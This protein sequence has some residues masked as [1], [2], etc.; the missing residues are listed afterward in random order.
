M[1]STSREATIINAGQGRRLDVLGHVVKVM[2]SSAD[3]Q[4]QSFV[5]E[6]ISPPG[7]FVPPHAHE[8]ED[9]YGYIVEG[10]FEVFVDGQIH[11]ATT[12]A[13]LY[14]PRHTAHG[15]RNSGSTPCKMIW[16]STPGANVDPFF[17]EL[18]ALPADAPPDMEKVMGIFARHDMQVFP[19]PWQ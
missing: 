5:F 16:I 7:F 13:V 17:E 14:F 8:H 19:P 4:G 10:V 12:E 18:G 3:T 11:E 6:T 15:F 9:E 1:S 2:L